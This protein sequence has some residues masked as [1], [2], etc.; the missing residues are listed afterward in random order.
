MTIERN[1]SPDGTRPADIRRYT[2]YDAVKLWAC[3]KKGRR[4]ALI[5]LCRYNLYDT[6]NLQ[7]VLRVAY[8]WGAT[9]SEL[10]FRRFDELQTG[11]AT[12]AVARALERI[13][14]PA[15]IPSA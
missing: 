14:Q 5:P 6:I 10:P 1:P 15:K 4:D 13:T 9:F 3:Y 7:T 2:G 11:C 8:N 12:E